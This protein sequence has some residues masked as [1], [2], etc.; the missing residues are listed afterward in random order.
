MRKRISVVGPSQADAS[1]L[2]LA[3][4]VGGEIAERGAILICGGLGGVMEAAARGAKRRGGLT[5]GILPT[6]DPAS[7]NP[8]IDIPIATGLGETRNLI[9]ARA[10]DA[11][12]AI[13][14]GYGTLSEIAFALRFKIPVI[15][16][17]TWQLTAPEGVPSPILVVGSPREAVER[18]LEAIR[19]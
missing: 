16:L 11:V 5:V 9:V 15:G 1:A 12:I 19:P 13:A 18:A 10:A 7:A 3:E 4:Q 14:G 2:A 8:F 6:P 17:G